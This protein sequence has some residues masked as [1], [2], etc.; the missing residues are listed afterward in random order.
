MPNKIKVFFGFLAL[1]AL[2]SVFTFFNS[3]RNSS[4]TF[5][6]PLTGSILEAIDQDADHDGLTNR[7]ESYWNTDFQN[8]DTD[9]DGFLDGEEVASGHNPTKLGPNDALIDAKNLTEKSS[10]LLVAGL[11]EGS[12]KVS[13]NKFDKSVDS[14]VDDLFYQSVVN[15]QKTTLSDLVD[16][17]IITT[18]SDKT[19][20]QEYLQSMNP[21]LGSFWVEDLKGFVSV[22]NIFQELDKTQ[23]YNN[24]KFV[25]AID[26]EVTK[27][28]NQIK[29]LVA[30][31]TPSNWVNTHNQLLAEMQDM[32]KNYLLFKNLSGDPMQGIISYVTLS[33]EFTENLPVLLNNYVLKK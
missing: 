2:F 31:Q 25:N 7:E 8:P 5:L 14:V 16:N 15:Q 6:K 29:Q 22:L 19:S 10:T 11:A 24:P 33:R 13:S 1:V 20:V 3:F 4:S 18:G 21:M 17:Q 23:D 30:V 27:L 9:G 26:N 12:L 28:Q 32:A